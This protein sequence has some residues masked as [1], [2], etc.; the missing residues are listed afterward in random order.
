[1]T[2]QSLDTVVSK[3]DASNSTMNLYREFT[4]TDRINLNSTPCSNNATGSCK[5]LVSTFTPQH[6]GAFDIG[7]ST[8]QDIA[9]EEDCITVCMKNCISGHMATEERCYSHCKE[10]CLQDTRKDFI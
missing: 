4:Q 2:S 1:M 7:R 3:I 10:V 9:Q 5:S 6:F 8:P